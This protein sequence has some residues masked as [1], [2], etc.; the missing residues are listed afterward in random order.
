[1]SFN[2]VA[3]IGGLVA[4]VLLILNASLL[5]NQPTLDDPIEDVVAYI[6]DDADLHRTAMLLGVLVLPF[7]A[8]FFAGIVSRVRDSDREHGEAWAIAAL[9]GAVLM[10]ATAAIG[11]SMAVVLFLRAGDG[12]DDSTV[13]A[14]YDAL[15]VSYSSIGIAVAA[16][17]GSVAVPAIRYRFWPSWYGWLSALVAAIGFVSVAGVAWTSVTGLVLGFAPFIGVLIWTLVTSLLMYR[18]S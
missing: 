13:R 17:T 16:L 1:M 14:V 10:L 15:L 11:D 18:E 6:N 5:G 12:L 2:R 8:V 7:Y 4:V 9:V 3:A